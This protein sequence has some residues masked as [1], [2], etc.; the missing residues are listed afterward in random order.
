MRPSGR[1][2]NQLRDISFTRGFTKHA[3]GSCLSNLVIP[4]CWS[5]P[6]SMKRYRHG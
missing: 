5:Q 6:R 2:P 3:E 4:M 1:Q